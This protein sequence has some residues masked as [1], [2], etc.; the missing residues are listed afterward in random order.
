MRVPPH[1]IFV[2]EA[3]RPIVI[4][5]YWHS[6][7]M[8]PGPSGTSLSFL[9]DTDAQRFRARVDNHTSHME[10]QLAR[11]VHRYRDAMIGQVNLFSHPDQQRAVFHLMMDA[12]DG[13]IR[14]DPQ[15]L[16]TLVHY[17]AMN[18]VTDMI[19]HMIT[20]GSATKNRDMLQNLVD[21]GFDVNSRDSD[22]RTP[23]HL[24]VIGNH[25]DTVRVLVEMCGADVHA[26]DLMKLLPWH[27][28]LEIGCEPLSDTRERIASKER[29]LRLLALHTDP[30]KVQGFLSKCVLEKLKKSPDAAIKIELSPPN[31]NGFED[32]GPMITHAADGSPILPHVDLKVLSPQEAT[33][34]LKE[35]FVAAWSKLPQTV[36]HARAN[37]ISQTMHFLL[38]SSLTF[39]GPLWMN[40]G[41]VTLCPL[42][43]RTI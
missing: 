40:L 6:P 15:T 3:Q 27:C 5:G 39:H 37:R 24:A 25:A 23:L 36:Q 14:S 1:T 33:A 30:A 11:F 32:R 13:L 31:H 41:T 21:A 34:L 38:G 22:Y 28:A 10:N 9:S 20:F 16:R 7:Y 43:Y 4:Q 8:L 42:V 12:A 17:M 19:Q 18:G 26:Q 2:N 29:I 35:F